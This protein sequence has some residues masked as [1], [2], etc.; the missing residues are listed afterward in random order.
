MKTAIKHQRI[1]PLRA[2]RLLALVALLNLPGC[3]MSDQKA[4][5][6]WPVP[7][8]EAAQSTLSQV[9]NQG[10]DHPI[11]WRT[12]FTFEGQI[13]PGPYSVDP[14]IWVYTKEFAERFGMPLE[15]VSD[16][17][18]G[19]EAAA[20]RKTKSGYVTC[21]WGGKKD[22]CKE[23]DAAVLELYFDTRKV[24][25]PWA[26]WSRES[27]QL[28]VSLV[29]SQFLLTPQRC[30]LRR[31]NSKSPVGD[32]GVSCMQR[33]HRQPLS[34]TTTGDEIFLFEK[35]MSYRGQGNFKRIYAYDKRAYPDLAWIQISYTR[36]VGLYNPPE[37]AVISL[38]T[39]T[40]PLGET[41]RTFHE[42]VLPKDFDRRIK[43]VLDAERESAREFYKK[44]LNM[45]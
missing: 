32:R 25:L 14:H 15:W 30:E 34:D 6:P 9:A 45:K 21:G 22:A 23:E 36:P 39:R 3:A 16:V 24:K 37:S 31:D 41:L 44:S 7:T 42:I 27:D 28:D 2:A 43:E 19:V 29:N 8:K 10:A 38:E 12:R 18:K 17:L 26:P 35:G 4:A 11:N 5:E 33:I 1:K 13:R 20:W 40:A